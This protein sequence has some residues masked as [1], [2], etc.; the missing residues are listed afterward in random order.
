MLKKLSFIFGAQFYPVE[1]KTKT[2]KI[3][4]D[5][6][7]TKWPHWNLLDVVSVKVSRTLLIVWNDMKLWGKRILDTDGA[8]AGMWISWYMQ[9][10]VTVNHRV[11]I[12]AWELSQAYSYVS[13]A[14]RVRKFSYTITLMTY[15]TLW[16]TKRICSSQ[17][18]ID[19][20][21]FE[22]SNQYVWLWKLE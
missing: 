6:W 11:S 21:L 15:P 7:M 4:V 9:P 13:H 8:W 3:H 10:S 18:E 22:C 12:T 14:V 17:G 19:V 5:H 16:N 20:C 2:T 1:H